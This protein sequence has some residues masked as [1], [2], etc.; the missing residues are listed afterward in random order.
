MKRLFTICVVAIATVIASVLPAAS[1]AQEL[2]AP[3]TRTDTQ[4]QS[5][6]AE[7]GQTL[8]QPGGQNA[9]LQPRGMQN[10]SVDATGYGPQAG[11]LS[12]SRS[13]P[14]SAPFSA[15]RDGLFTHH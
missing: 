9:V 6:Q 2:N 12:E 1:F 5:T 11:G 14:R 8:N 10:P 7:P 15:A 4:M 3:P 13:A